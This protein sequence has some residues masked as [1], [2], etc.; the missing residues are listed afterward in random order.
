MT[1]REIRPG[2][3]EW[4]TGLDELVSCKIPASLRIEGLPIPEKK[5]CV[6][7]V[8]TRR[9][10]VVGREVAQTFARAFVEAGFC[11]VSGMAM[12]IDSQAHSG[13]L[14]AGGHTVAV[15]GCG[16]DLDYPKQN[17]V[18]RRRIQKTGT[19]V[20]EY[21]DDAE[22]TPYTFP[23][24]NRIIAG[25]CEGV[26]V[27]EGGERSGA[28]ITARIALDEDREIF[29]VPGS[30]RNPYAVCPNNLIRVNEARLVTSP[31][32]VFELLA[33]SIIWDGTRVVGGAA[34]NLSELEQ[35]I[36]RAIGEVPVGIEE[37]SAAV[38]GAPGAIALAV[39]KLE[40]R[41]LIG[42]RY[43]GAF[44]VAPGGLRAIGTLD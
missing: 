31:Q 10:T 41:G 26:V 2:C 5:R 37:I 21:P 14:D 34:P 1:R 27:V 7:I 23:E 12:G 30:I 8:G 22:P 40:V 18:L 42:R 13:A 20:T 4:P 39:A 11:V 6:A 3:E 44:E 9:P 29:A 24:R 15:L 25:L 38:D 17:G 16:L 28:A 33:P 19:L 35:A 32:H 43:T 36:L